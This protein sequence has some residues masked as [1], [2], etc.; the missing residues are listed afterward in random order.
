MTSP[1]YLSPLVALREVDQ[2]SLQGAKMDS[3]VSYSPDRERGAHSFPF[4]V[5]KGKL[6]GL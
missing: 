1:S 5:Q 4:G 3:K 2:E 6:G